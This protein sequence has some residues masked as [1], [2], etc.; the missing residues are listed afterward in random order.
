MSTRAQVI[1]KDEF[2][3]ELRFYRHSDGYPEGIMPSL[4]KFLC[5]VKEGKIKDNVE[6]AAGWLILIGAEEYRQRYDGT[7][8]ESV[9]QPSEDYKISGGKCGAFEPCPC[10]SLHGDIAYLY[11]INLHEKSIREVPSNEWSKY[12]NHEENN[13]VYYTGK[14]VK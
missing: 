3:D 6:Q 12:N 5:W 2:G 14:L 7:L 11:E 4:E 13:C 1:I 9:T 10:R 8:K